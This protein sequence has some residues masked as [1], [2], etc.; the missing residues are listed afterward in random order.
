MENPDYTNSLSQEGENSVAPSHNTRRSR[1][2][3]S[4]SVAWQHAKLDVLAGTILVGGE[5]INKT[6]FFLF[7]EL[8]Y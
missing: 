2:S 8:F 6:H 5:K 3:F 1:Q 4:L 7:I